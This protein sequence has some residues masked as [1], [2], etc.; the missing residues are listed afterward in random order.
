MGYLGMSWYLGNVKR[1]IFPFP[2][3]PRSVVVMIMIMFQLCIISLSFSKAL[4]E[5]CQVLPIFY[6]NKHSW[7]QEGA[8]T[9]TTL[10]HHCSSPPLQC[11]ATSLP[12]STSD[13]TSQWLKTKLS[14]CVVSPVQWWRRW[15][16]GAR[17]TLFLTWNVQSWELL[18]RKFVLCP[19]D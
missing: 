13:Q 15:G 14:N 8:T 7:P 10:Q 18:G 5:R 12:L 2:L 9:L 17:L 1:I 11:R 6:P 3:P 4:A 16:D 19:S